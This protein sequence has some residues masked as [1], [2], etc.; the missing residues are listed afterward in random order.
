MFSDETLGSIEG[1]DPV[2]HQRMGEL[3]ARWTDID[4]D[5]DGTQFTVGG[6]GFAAMGRKDL[7][8]ILQER[9]ADLG[10]TCTSAPRRPT[11]TSCSATTTSSSPPTG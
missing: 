11:S 5:F 7:L 4:V 8:R 9:A 6:Q 2:V 3:F 1:A 10:V